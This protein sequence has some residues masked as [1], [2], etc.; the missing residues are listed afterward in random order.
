MKGRF[1]VVATVILHLV[2]PHE[3]YIRRKSLRQPGLARA[4][5]SHAL[6]FPKISSGRIRVMR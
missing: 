2:G 1:L 6:S 5:R 4:L 3:E